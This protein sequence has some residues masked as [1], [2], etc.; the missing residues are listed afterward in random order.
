MFY[1]LEAFFSRCFLDVLDGIRMVSL[2]SSVKFLGFAT[3]I[4]FGSYYICWLSSVARSSPFAMWSI[5]YIAVWSVYVNTVS[6]LFAKVITFGAKRLKC[7]W[8][9]K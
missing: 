9:C 8:C 7:N 3:R 1:S 2:V 6:D 4:V 5:P